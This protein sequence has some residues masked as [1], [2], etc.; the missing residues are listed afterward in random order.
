MF[1]GTTETATSPPNRLP[2]A[3]D[4]EFGSEDILPTS[5]LK[6]GEGITLKP[7]QLLLGR[8]FEEFTI[9]NG[10][11]GKLEGRST[12]ARLGLSVHCTGDFINPGWRGRMPLQLVNHGK[13]PL[14][15]T[16]FLPVAQLLVMRVSGLSEQP[17]GA[18]Q[19][20]SKYMNDAGDPSRYWLDSRIKKLQQGCGRVNVSDQVKK[21]LA[22]KVGIEDADLL[23]RFTAFMSTLQSH[24]VT[25]A[26]EILERFAK[27][28]R[29]RYKRQQQRQTFFKWLPPA[30]LT[31]SLGGLVKQ[32]YGWVHY[33]FRGLTGLMILPSLW[34]LFEAAPP[35]APFSQREK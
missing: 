31:V 32:P 23:D 2:T 22:N 26:E 21:D 1:L 13:F 14:I 15:L 34:Y 8:T 29:L 10:Y 12:F 18:P 30:L 9:P 20:G 16:P 6:N 17:Y 7:G 3:G 5:A 28:D 11:A 24:E 19:L 33:V 35:A 27:T 4:R 25:S